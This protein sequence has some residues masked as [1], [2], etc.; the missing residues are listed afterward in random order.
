MTELVLQTPEVFK[1]L[2]HPSRYKGAFGGRGSGKSWHFASMV[3]ERCLLK[4]GS[5]IVCIREIQ[6]TLAQSAKALIESTIQALGVGSEFRVF[7]DKIETPGGGLI[8]FLGMQDQNAESIKSLE[9]YDIAWV[10]EAQTL[11]ARSLALLRPTIRADG[12]E[13]WFTWNPRRKSDAVDEFLRAA[14]LQNAIVV[15]ANFADN[16]FF[17]ATL[18]EEMQLDRERY[19]D[20]FE[21]IWLGDY[22]KAFEGAYYAGLLADARRDG[23]MCELKPDPIIPYK[24]FWDIGGAGAKADACAIWVV[25]FAGAEIRVLDYIEGQGQVLGYYT[26]ELHHRGYGK[27]IC[28]LP[29]DGANTNAV[30]GLRYA[31]HLRDAEFQ[32]TVKRNMGAGAVAMRIEAVRRIFNRCRFDAKKCEAGIEALG[33]YHEKKDEQRSVGLGP[34]HDWSSHAADAFGLMALSYE[35]PARDGGAAS[36]PDLSCSPVAARA[37]E[38]PATTILWR[39]AGG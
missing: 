18:E 22:A 13:L 30:T 35:D 15:K 17:P 1:P 11:S 10:E 7:F 33:F 2:D 25:Q 4:P 14:T 21:H 31:D 20:R 37:A 9:G 19:P 6:K 3:V 23:R 24:L 28:Y 8:I 16:P 36:G 39:T 29:H 26:N 12:S 38:G 32:V 5:R 27:A 34:S